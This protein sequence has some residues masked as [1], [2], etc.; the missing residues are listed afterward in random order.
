[1]IAST[2]LSVLAAEETHRELP[3]PAWAIGLIAFGILLFLLLVTL[4]FNRDR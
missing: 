4:Q 3:L 2:A 1:M